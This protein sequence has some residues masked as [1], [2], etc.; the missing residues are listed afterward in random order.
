MPGSSDAPA[1]REN[2]F[3]SRSTAFMPFCALKSFCASL[4]FVFSSGVPFLIRL[5]KKSRKARFRG[6]S[7]F[8]KA[9]SRIEAAFTRCLSAVLS[10]SFNAENSGASFLRS[11]LVVRYFFEVR[12]FN[13]S[14]ES[15]ISILFIITNS[16]QIIPQKPKSN[17][18][19]L[20]LEKCR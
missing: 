8:K 4:A 16:I 7:I 6:S 3:A 2:L 9:S 17:N 11:T 18:M 14:S 1:K 5:F 13:S 19:G 10:P 15:A 20:S 12:F